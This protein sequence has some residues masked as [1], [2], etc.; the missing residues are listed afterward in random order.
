MKFILFLLF[1]LS[2]CGLRAQ[3]LVPNPS[4]EEWTPENRVSR[5]SSSGQKVKNWFSPTNGT[6]DYF[7]KWSL[8]DEDPDNWHPFELAR[9]G[10]HFMGLVARFNFELYYDEDYREYIEVKM[11]EPLK[12]GFKYDVTFHVF[13]APNAKFIITSMGACLTENILDSLNYDAYM[14][15]ENLVNN[16]NQRFLSDKENWMEVTGTYKAKGGEQYLTI[17]NFLPNSK[18]R[19]QTAPGVAAYNAYD[20]SYYYIDDVEVSLVGKEFLKR[21]TINLDNIVFKTNAAELLCGSL[22]TLQKIEQLLTDYPE[23]V[24]QIAGHTDNQGSEIKNLKLS[25]ERAKAVADFLGTKGIDKGR[26]KFVGYGSQRPRATN[27]TE[28]G[29]L[30][31]RRVEMIILKK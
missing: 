19:V 11:L 12:S 25:T 15:C 31:N 3:N 13:C 14:P 30:K 10:R 9:T 22:E 8:R 20:Y 17:G 7:D 21:D 27:T 2:L 5:G 4:F 26:I 29:R 24:I 18:T 6:P 16:S 1:G 28:E 23:M